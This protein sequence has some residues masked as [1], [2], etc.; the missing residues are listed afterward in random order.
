MPLLWALTVFSCNGAGFN[1]RAR[2]KWD[3]DSASQSTESPKP[4]WLVL[5]MFTELFEL[6]GIMV[7]CR[8]YQEVLSSP[9]GFEPGRVR[10]WSFQEL[11]C[12]QS[13]EVTLFESQELNL[14][15]NVFCQ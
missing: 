2:M 14:L 13:P 5:E 1:L 10:I 8:S 11:F 12:E 4:Q 3:L 6:Q 7:L 15:L 9:A